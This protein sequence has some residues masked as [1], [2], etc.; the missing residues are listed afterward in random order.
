M[1]LIVKYLDADSLRCAEAVSESW[2]VA[3]SSLCSEKIWES[4]LK[5]KVF[6]VVRI[7]KLFDKIWET[8]TYFSF[9]KLVNTNFI[10]GIQL[11]LLFFRSHKNQ[12]GKT[13]MI[14]MNNTTISQRKKY[15]K[16]SQELNIWDFEMFIQNMN[17]LLR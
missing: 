11:L 5:A 17:S 6:N 12:Y 3:I 10:R 16:K 4:L 14:W 1:E 2:K 7:F 9:S 15:A 8:I 13:F